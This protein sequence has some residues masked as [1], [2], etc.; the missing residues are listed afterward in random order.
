MKKNL[1][2]L[3]CQVVLASI[4]YL[5]EAQITLVKDLYPDGSLSEIEQVMVKDETMYFSALGSSLGSENALIRTDGSETGTQIIENYY[6]TSMTQFADVLYYNDSYINILHSDGTPFNSKLSMAF[7]TLSLT[8]DLMVAGNK[9]Y[10]SLNDGENSFIASM[11]ESE[12]LETYSATNNYSNIF[13]VGDAIYFRTENDLKFYTCK[14]ENGSVVTSEI[15]N[16]EFIYEFDFFGKIGSEVFFFPTITNDTTNYA[17]YDFHTEIWQLID[18]VPTTVTSL[19]DNLATTNFTNV[20]SELYFIAYDYNEYEQPA[21]LWKTDGT[22]AGTMEVDS[23]VENYMSLY[24]GDAHLY[25]KKTNGELWS[26]DIASQNKTMV[27]AQV[28][29]GRLVVYNDELYYFKNGQ[30]GPELWKSDGTASGTW[31]LAEGDMLVNEPDKITLMGV[32]KDRLIFGAQSPN[33]GHELFKYELSYNCGAEHVVSY[34]PGRKQNGT[35]IN[36]ARREAN[37]SLSISQENQREN[38]VSL[39]FG[40]SI[41]LELGNRVY[42]DGTAEPEI[43]LKETSYGRANEMCYSSTGYSYP[44]QAHV[45]L[46]ADGNQWYS[47]P[48]VYCRTSFLDI[49]P[50]VKQG[51]AYAKYIKITDVS[52]PNHFPGN[53]DGYDLDAVITCR[54]EVAIAKR[55]MTN[56][57]QADKEDIAEPDFINHE[58]GELATKS[59]KI[60]P[61]PLEGEIMSVEMN[62]VQTG[63]MEV[64]VIDMLGQ[65][66]TVYNVEATG[67]DQLIQLNLRNL[68]SGTYL[69]RISTM[70]NI[71]T[72]KLIIR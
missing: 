17:D 46:S 11:D 9:L 34:T 26:V 43:I 12:N 62:G 7:D 25:Y 14:L 41:T 4:S 35:P 67:E 38:F 2:T 3:L 60:F 54:E 63:N 48:N 49:Q 16:Y 33:Y 65:V 58:A 66:K 39:G 37:K 31:L 32:V 22:A 44:E 42:D 20:G 52:D 68:E 18:G 47:L 59:M 28:I 57:R 50:A 27:G 69:V 40:G 19:P 56:A 15:K 13:T 6:I 71:S 8:S 1:P 61:N 51:M 70:D 5:C 64:Q 36:S 55:I 24:A 21:K 45:E 53:A 72:Q 30:T 23:D 29:G 10:F